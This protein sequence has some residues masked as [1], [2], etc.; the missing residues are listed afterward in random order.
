VL[1]PAANL[2]KP[3]LIGDNSKESKTHVDTEN[4][5]ETCGVLY[6]VL[7]CRALHDG[8]GGFIF[9]GLI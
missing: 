5:P 4:H 1:R 7:C 2:S 3:S 9:E 6:A 8:N